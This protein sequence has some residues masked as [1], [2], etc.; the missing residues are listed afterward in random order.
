MFDQFVFAQ[1]M[2]SVQF[3]MVMLAQVMFA[4]SWQGNP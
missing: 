4:Q 3:S 2:S 1:S